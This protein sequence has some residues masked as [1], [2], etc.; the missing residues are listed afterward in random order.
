M[1]E[2]TPY[3][4]PQPRPREP[5]ATQE[6]HRSSIAQLK[7]KYAAKRAL[8]GLYT[9]L[10]C[11]AADV[12]QPHLRRLAALRSVKVEEPSFLPG[13]AP[14]GIGYDCSMLNQL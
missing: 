1:T 6:R 11:A 8:E 2:V 13:V 12:S 5:L 14:P 7:N 10:N 4:W 9:I 3:V